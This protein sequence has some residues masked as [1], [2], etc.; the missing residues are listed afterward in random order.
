VICFAY[1]FSQVDQIF[2]NLPKEFV[3]E[4]LRGDLKELNHDLILALHEDYK[5]TKGGESKSVTLTL[6]ETSVKA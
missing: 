3:P 4:E 5:K 6:P 1:V 2:P